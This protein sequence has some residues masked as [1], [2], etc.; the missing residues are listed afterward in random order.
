[1]PPAEG[2][3]DP[4]PA[5]F[6]P[7]QLLAGTD[8]VGH[9]SGDR[10]PGFFLFKEED[11]LVQSPGNDRLQKVFI[12]LFESRF[13]H[14]ADIRFPVSGAERPEEETGRSGLDRDMA[15]A[16]V[17]YKKAAAGK[18][19]EALYR[20]GMV[21]KNGEGKEAVDH[22]RMIRC[23]TA[24]A[25]AGHPGAQFQLG[26]CCEN[27]IGVPLNVGKAKHWYDKAAAKGHEKARGRAAALGERRE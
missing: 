21:Y 24:A 17:W 6:A 14:Q 18:D 5:Q 3:G 25:E 11:P 20:M 4:H 7:L 15:G 2:G 19:P 12:P 13:V 16:A 9:G 22:A 8:P 27:G 26:Y 1:M 23:L 10:K